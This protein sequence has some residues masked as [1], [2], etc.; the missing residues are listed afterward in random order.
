VQQRVAHLFRHVQGVL[1]LHP[2]QQRWASTV[3]SGVARGPR[4]ASRPPQR[5][6][7]TTS[8]RLC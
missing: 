6:E 5:T 8:I 1:D 7:R 2:D 4:G 3:S